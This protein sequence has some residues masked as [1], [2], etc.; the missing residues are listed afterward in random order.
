MLW[1]SWSFWINNKPLSGNPKMTPKQQFCIRIWRHTHNCNRLP[2]PPPNHGN[3]EP[4]ESRTMGIQ[5]PLSDMSNFSL[6]T[7][8]TPAQ[9]NHISS[10]VGNMS[11]TTLV[12]CCQHDVVSVIW[13]LLL[14]MK[15]RHSQLRMQALLI[16]V[17]I[18]G[19]PSHNCHAGWYNAHKPN[20]YEAY[21][22]FWNGF[23]FRMLLCLMRR[24]L[25]SSSYIFF[26]L[27]YVNIST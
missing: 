14:H 13:T 21:V 26:T 16:T 1:Q 11:A 20:G 19:N 27:S 5:N 10:N 24:I 3:P 7:R 17:S 9:Q 25:H 15:I 8:Q 2:R 4:W 23:F 18:S 6:L 22:Q 12:T